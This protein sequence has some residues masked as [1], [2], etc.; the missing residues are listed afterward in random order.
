MKVKIT[1][2]THKSLRKL[3]QTSYDNAVTAPR[4]RHIAADRNRPC[5]KHDITLRTVK[6]G[7][8]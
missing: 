2:K 3:A 7:V 1:K 8:Y 6:K 5:N 4:N